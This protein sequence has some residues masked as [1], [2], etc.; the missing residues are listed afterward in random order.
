MSVLTSKE[1]E[2]F[3]LV[4]ASI[5][6]WVFQ[7]PDAEQEIIAAAAKAM[8]LVWDQV[9]TWLSFTRILDATNEWLDQHAK[10]R[11]TRRQTDETDE[12]LRQRLRVYEDAVT[13]ASLNEVMESLLEADGITADGALLELR[14]YR[15]HLLTHAAIIQAV[16]AALLSD[17]E[18][19]D[20]SDGTT[21]ETYEFDTGGG[22][23]PG[24]IAVDISTAVTAEDVSAALVAA[25]TGD[26]TVETDLYDET[27]IYLV[28]ASGNSL[29]LTDSVSE[30][31]FTVTSGRKD[32]YLSR[33]YRI[34]SRLNTI[35]LIL[36]YGT[37]DATRD[38][39]IEAARQKKGGGIRVL[40]E[41]R[42]TP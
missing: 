17:G 26:F 4:K 23:S 39:I 9:D 19:F 38:S 6:S 31:T 21:T 32:A 28:P 42:G 10:D 35:I 27:K 16:A 30:P 18:T 22:V 14:R 33:G 7:S 24:N 13:V 1:Q 11:G 15:A 36:P 3:D 5:P 20:V 25:L 37:T 41:V 29:A 12:A 40:V 8:K 34:G 2:L